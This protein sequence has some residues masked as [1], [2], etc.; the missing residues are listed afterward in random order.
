M[1]KLLLLWGIGGVLVI[2]GA[3]LYRLTPIALVPI[4]DGSLTTFHW[5]IIVLWSLFN[6]HAEGY[7]G[8]QQRFSPRTVARAVY[9]GQ[10][11]TPLRVALAPLFC[12][13]F[14]HATKRVLIAA[15]GVLIAVLVLVAIIRSLDQPWRGIVDVG[16]VIGLGW[17]TI[18]LLVFFVAALFGRPPD[19]DPG[20]SARATPP[21]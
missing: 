21:A 9:L 13:G 14:F 12:M 6:A 11:P 3:A 7:K 5:V 16:V 17:G 8:F 4:N 1:R 19:F 15:W 2:L 10:H 20:V 18:S